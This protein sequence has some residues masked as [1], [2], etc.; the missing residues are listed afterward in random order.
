MLSDDEP[1]NNSYWRFKEIYALQPGIG[2]EGDKLNDFKF[3]FGGAVFR[4]L[5]MKLNRYGIYGAL[6]VML[7]DADPKSTRISRVFPPFQGANGGPSGGPIMNLDG[8]EIDA[9]V[10]PLAVRPG[11]L[12]ET[13]DTFSFAS[14]VAPTL[15][16]KVHVTVTGPAGF[17]AVING[18]ANAIGYFYD[19]AQDF[20]VT[21]PGVYHVSVTATFDS[22][23]SAG[24]MSPPYPTGTLLGAVEQGFDFYV[25]PANSAILGTPHPDWSVIKSVTAVPLLVKAPKDMLAGTVHYTIGMPGFLLETGSVRLDR[26]YA[27]VVTD[28]VRL[29]RTFPN[30]DTRASRTDW[31][32]SKRALVDTV[33]VNVLLEGD[34]GSFYGRHFTL[35]GPDLYAPKGK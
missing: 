24:P 2:V 25:I 11:T 1:V 16:A 31:G 23:T 10:V 7:P 34:D 5:T 29:S 8:K 20:Q 4:D 9:F 12:L 33:W 27:T 32:S 14:H 17:S 6:W 18:R 19:P 35:Q 3:L 21:S 22:A 26:G 15:P 13:G 30:I 28:P